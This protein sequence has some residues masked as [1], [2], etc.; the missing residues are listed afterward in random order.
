MQAKEQHPNHEA[1]G[2]QHHVVGVLCCRRAGALH[3]IDGIIRKENYVDMFKQH[4]ETSVRKLMLGRKWIYQ[5][6]KTPSILPK[7]WQNG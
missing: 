2:W 3:K 4:F 6:D 7:L 5:T 1:Q